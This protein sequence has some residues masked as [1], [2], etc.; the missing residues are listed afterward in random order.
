MLLEPRL[1]LCVFLFF[2]SV[3][4]PCD[5]AIK[6]DLTDNTGPFLVVLI[7]SRLLDFVS[8]VV[9]VSQHELDL[10]SW[11][12]NPVGFV[13]GETL[14]QLIGCGAIL[15]TGACPREDITQ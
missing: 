2:W 3:V 8:L 12:I 9:G 14:F 13:L 6:Y 7:N 11:F 15:Q 1:W 10:L 4:T 5:I